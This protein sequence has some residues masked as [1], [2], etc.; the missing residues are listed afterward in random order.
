MESR[1]L[2]QRRNRSDHSCSVGQGTEHQDQHEHCKIE[3]FRKWTDGGALLSVP[4]IFAGNHCNQADVIVRTRMYTVHTERAVHVAFL[5]R[6]KEFQFTASLL[7]SSSDAIKGLATAANIRLSDFHLER[8]KQRLNKMELA[9]RTNVFAK[10]STLK[11]SIDQ[12]GRQEIRE[13]DPGSQP[14]TVP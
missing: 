12:N 2:Q 14:W 13:N 10:A 6:L 11:K 5:F 4:E 9:D 1:A 3:P 8:R 7:G